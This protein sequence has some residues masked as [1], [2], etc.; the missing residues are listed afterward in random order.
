MEKKLKI[1]LF[2]MYGLYNYGCEAIA[3]GTYELIKQAWPNSDVILYTRFPKE[4]KQIVNDL[5]ITIKRAPEKKGAILRRIIN[6]ILRMINIEQK[7][8]IWDAEAVV[9]ECDLV[10]SVG[11]DIYTIPKYI[12]KN[13][14]E[15]KHSGI[16]EFG[17]TVLRSKPYV[18]WGASIGPFGEKPEVR[19]Y[20]FR[21][22]KQVDQIFCREETSFNYLNKNNVNGNVQLCSDPAFYIKDTSKQKYKKSS[23]I[24]IALN[25]SPL[26]VFEQVG[27][28]NSFKEQVIE[29]IQ[30]LLSISNTEVVL[31]PHVLSPLSNKDNDLDYLKDIYDSIPNNIVKSV[32]LLEG[33]EGFLG[34]KEFLKTC[35]IVIAARMHCAVNA[36][37]EGIPTIFLAYSQKAI[38]MANYIYNDTKWVIHLMDIK[39]ELKNKTVEMLTSKDEISKDIKSRI[40][41][42]RSDESRIIELFRNIK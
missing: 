11:G 42:I 7:L 35:D 5:D 30:D 29:T 10:F 23:N 19:D 21:H 36:V 16:V 26:S 24:R 27:E 41:K 34:T 2:G 17:N 28:S 25:L 1:A 18:I 22:L 31:V 32:S 38:G 20:Y 14:K 15:T 4:D 6:R 3:R 37:C 40:T 33:A 39:K 8:I 13:K 12:L 9:N